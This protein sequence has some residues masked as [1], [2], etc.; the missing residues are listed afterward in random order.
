MNVAC[1]VFGHQPMFGTDGRHM[2]WA[3]ARCGGA[4]GTKQYPTAADARRYAA[5][6]NRRDVDDLGKRAPL[7]GLLPLRLWQR[8]R[9]R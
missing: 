3:C 6:F 4:A 9:R 7:L 5:A 8:F 1:R 2:H